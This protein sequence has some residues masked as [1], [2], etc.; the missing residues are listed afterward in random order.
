MVF[1]VAA[2]IKT[3]VINLEKAQ[4]DKDLKRIKYTEY[5]THRRDAKEVI[6]R[7]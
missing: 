4:E 6:I 1:S 3:N 2:W 7:I 5:L